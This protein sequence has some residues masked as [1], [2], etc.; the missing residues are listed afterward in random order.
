MKSIQLNKKPGQS[1]HPYKLSVKNILLALLIITG[2]QTPLKAQT[3]EQYTKPS[4][5]FG[6]A[7]AANFNFHRGSTQELNEDFTSPAAFHNGFGIGLFLGPTIEYYR[8]NS[9]LGFIFQM[10]YD[11][12]KG[13]FA[14]TLTPCNCP[15]DLS[16]KLSYLTIEPSLRIAPFKSDFYL[17]GG[18]RFAYNL[19]RSFIYQ[20]KPNPDYPD[21]IQG[22][23]VT[24]DFSHV[25]QLLVSMQIGVGYDIY[26]SGQDKKTQFVLSPFVSFQPYFGQSP[27]SIETWNITTVRAGATL[28]F[29]RGKSTSAKEINDNSIVDKEKEK[30]AK[31]IKSKNDVNFTVVAPKNIPSERTVRETFPVLNYVFFDLGSTEIP[32]RYVLLEK[33]QVKD[34]KEEQVELF[35]P[36]NLSGRSERQMVV[37]YNILNIIGDRMVKNP[38]T[39]IK[40]VGSSEGS[41][42]DARIMAE[43]V[44]T[45]LV[46]IFAI[47]GSRITTQG[48]DNPKKPDEQPGVTE[49]LVLL[50][51]ADRRVTIESSSPE[52]LMEFQSGPTAP[53][54]PVTFVKVQKA[55]VESYV[56]FKNPG[57]TEMFTSWS[58]E[59]KD[60]NGV[61]QYFGPYYTDEVAI[62]GKE[63]LGTRA[64]GNYKV[65][66][67]GTTSK[68]KK[69]KKE[70][71]VHMVLWTPDV[72]DEAMRFSVTYA[73]NESKAI[74]KYE[75]YL[76][77]VVAPKIPKNGKVI[78]HGHTD[79]I[80]D[81][82]NNQKLSAARANDVKN[83]LQKALANT[84]RTDVTF[85][86]LGL[87][88]DT[89]VSPFENKYP[90]E[91]FYNRTVVIDI[92]P[93]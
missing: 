67:I 66:M 89:K 57:A 92:V 72:K 40:L 36:K 55:P 83:I 26:L 10:G 38:S 90:E 88:E 91:R 11:S 84:G 28:K 30:P 75:K 61:V 42:E 45:Y 21:Q 63:I 86:V 23:P 7:G 37:Y 3:Q 2:F 25:E 70:T 79:I 73:F 24:G 52:M 17:Y 4:W 65:K 44:K 78:I 80:G 46:D 20:L 14:E 59:V 8:P 49:G 69:V 34:F 18:P 50:R 32:S 22:D 15:A 56:V 12:R 33:E 64:E 93:N 9:V 5:W 58:V 48:I 82:A 13:K 39:T 60:E 43:S 87:G 85:E 1:W 81:E 54:K 16:T 31:E 27:R 68:N 53:L 19:N 76:T 29:G 35:T 47:D 74:E 41:P 71:D 6:A 51:Q 62:P 77:E